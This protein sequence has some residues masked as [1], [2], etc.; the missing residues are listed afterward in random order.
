MSEKKLIYDINGKIKEASGSFYDDNNNSLNINNLSSSNIYV[1]LPDGIAKVQNNIISS[2]QFS[3]KQILAWNSSSGEW[4]A[5]TPGTIGLSDIN[6]A[7]GS[8]VSGSVTNATVTSL[9]N[10]ISGVLPVQ[11]G[12]T[13]LTNADYLT[14]ESIL[15]YDPSNPTK[16]SLLNASGQQNNS[17]V[18]RINNEWTFITQ[19]QVTSSVEISI[20]TQSATWVKPEGTKAIRVLLQGGGG[21]GGSGA[22]RNTQFTSTGGGGGSAGSFI[23]TDIIYVEDSFTNRLVTVGKGGV[24]GPFRGPGLSGN[25]GADGKSS[26]FHTYEAIGGIGG[27]GGLINA[28]SVGG[29]VTPTTDNSTYN[30]NYVTYNNQKIFSKG[31]DGGSGTNTNGTDL[32]LFDTT[33]YYGA[34]GGGGGAGLQ[35]NSFINYPGGDADIGEAINGGNISSLNASS[36]LS[37]S[38]ISLFNA[39][40]SSNSQY[41][42]IF[43]SSGGGGGASANPYTRLIVDSSD[44]DINTADLIMD[45][46]T[47]G[48][49]TIIDDS[50]N[51][52]TI[53]YDGGVLTTN[54]LYVKSGLRSGYCDGLTS[55]VGFNAPH[56]S[57][58]T[59]DFT[60]EAW[61][62]PTISASSGLKTIF[63][64]RS[65]FS[66]NGG[67]IL[68]MVSGN[69]IRF[70]DNTSTVG[71]T[72][73]KINANQWSHVACVRRLGAVSVYINGTLDF[74]APYT[75]NDA[76]IKVW[77]GYAGFSPVV[78]NSWTGYIDRVRIHSSAIY[79]SNFTPKSTLYKDFLPTGIKSG[80]SGSNG[81]FGSGGGGGGASIDYTASPDH[82]LS[83]VDYL[84][85]IAIIDFDYKS[86]NTV[87]DDSLY[88]STITYNS[89]ASISNFTISGGT[90]GYFD[91][92]TST[93]GF[94]FTREASF[95][96]G[97]FTL[98]A[99]VYPE[100]YHSTDNIYI[101]DLR[102]AFSPNGGFVVSI[103][104]T[105]N[106]RCNVNSDNTYT[107]L[108]TNIIPLNSWTHVA[109]VREAN[110]N[111]KVYINGVLDST[112][113]T[114]GSGTVSSLTDA[115]TTTWI[116][117]AGFSPVL[118]RAFKGYID[119]VR[120]HKSAI[121]TSNFSTSTSPY[122][123]IQQGGNGG[124]G[125]VAIISYKF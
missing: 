62:Y 44:V 58:G 53:T 42:N 63:D 17:L 31:L 78:P 22:N 76:G 96:T 68:S 87:F 95:G 90:S 77:I 72:T 41:N 64:L 123:Y 115:G 82:N 13:G 79:T 61:V 117:Y 60:L 89:G 18:A 29:G 56:T 23:D 113:T 92:S 40:I 110:T 121:Y 59:G 9:T 119:R 83:D 70:Q 5:Y 112:H 124:D 2:I 25:G 80:G 19:S 39:T 118:S 3:D 49:S 36:A 120:I 88:N 37:Q 100:E 38:K 30:I 48:G 81:A 6:F 97:P 98:E 93:A 26:K 69:F 24:G 103:N 125:Y 66:T 51:N 86:S 12:G 67:P 122:K 71:T 27:S 35:G 43:L 116:G 99:W 101:F 57:F 14:G 104:P 73:T 107:I 111:I 85:S 74:S 65:S 28:T 4:Y 45:F 108:S 84:N 32:T 105:G 8:D 109:I 91:K 106:L 21:G 47:N 20:F 7:A 50:N 102:S 33:K 54:S 94:Y 46:E 55:R 10:V 34:G 11:R 114:T 1:N 16:F 52:R 15:Y 75:S